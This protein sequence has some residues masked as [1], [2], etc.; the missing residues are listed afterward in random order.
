MLSFKH[1]FFIHWS[2]SQMMFGITALNFKMV[3]LPL[4]H[5]F[6]QHKLV[7]NREEIRNSIH[8]QTKNEPSIQAE[9]CLC[10]ASFKRDLSLHYRRMSCSNQFDPNK[11]IPP[12]IRTMSS[13]VL[14]SNPCTLIQDCQ[15]ITFP[16]NKVSFSLRLTWL[17]NSQCLYRYKYD[18]LGNYSMA[19]IRFNYLIF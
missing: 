2:I 4:V 19:K 13:W 3:V 10:R 18:L 8:G 12:I 11:G 6:K 17:S 9:M 5:S 16:F 7:I 15:P 14:P 1:F